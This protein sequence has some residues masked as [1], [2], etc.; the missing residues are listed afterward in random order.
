M[1]LCYSVV[2]SGIA[3]VATSSVLYLLVL[4]CAA[5]LAHRATQS[6]TPLLGTALSEMPGPAMQITVLIPAH[7]EELVLAATLESLKLQDYPPR[8]LEILVVAD[9][10]TDATAQIARDYDATVL[11]RFNAEERGKGYALDWAI[12]QLLARPEPPEAVVIVDADTWVA[13]DFVGIIA[14]RLAAQMA[15]CQDAEACCVLQGRYGVLNR[16]EGWRAALMSGAFELVNHI[17]PP[18]PL[19]QPARPRLPLAS[20]ARRS[21]AYPALRPLR[22]GLPDIC[23]GRILDR[24]RVSRGLRRTAQSAILYGL[25]ACALR[26]QSVEASDERRYRPDGMDSHGPYRSGSAAGLRTE[27]EFSFWREARSMKTEAKAPYWFSSRQ[28]T[29][30]IGCSNHGFLAAGACRVMTAPASGSASIQR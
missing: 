23:A 2:V 20:A 30:F 13:P 5:A 10:C 3:L 6:S 21:L 15:V 1:S 28:R 9:N 27:V 17:R 16:T 11:E 22:A 8:L 4:L 7:E 24:R 18:A 12:A 26:E 14:V 25:E 19:G 29:I